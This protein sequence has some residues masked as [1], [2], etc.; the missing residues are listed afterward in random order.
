MRVFKLLYRKCHAWYGVI[1]MSFESITL[2]TQDKY[3]LRDTMKAS[4]CTIENWDFAVKL[5]YILC[6]NAPFIGEYV[7]SEDQFQD[8]VTDGRKLFS[9]L[10]AQGMQSLSGLE[11][12]ELTC[13][14]IFLTQRIEA[15]RNSSEDDGQIW[16]HILS[17]LGYDEIQPSLSWQSCYKKMTELIRTNVPYFAEY[18]QKYYNTLRI[19]ALTPADSISELFE[20]IYSFYRNN[21]ECQYNNADNAFEILTENI[22]KRLVNDDNSDDAQIS[23]GSGFWKLK[24]SLKFL[25]SHEPTYMAAVCDAIAGKMDILLR[26]DTPV[27]N[28][29]NRWD[30]LLQE[31]FDKKTDAEKRRMQNVRLRQVNTKI[32]SKSEQ[33]HPKYRLE[34]DNIFICIPSIRLP[35]I[36]QRPI[37]RLYQSGNLVTERTLSVYGN[38][39]CYTTREYSLSLIDIDYI[40]W[41]D[42]LNFQLQIYCDEN[43]IYDSAY[44][45][46]REYIIFNSFG[47]ESNIERCTNGQIRL[48]TDSYSIVEIDDPNEQ[49]N[50]SSTKDAFQLFEISLISA[51]KIVVNH[52][53]ILLS[54]PKKN[55][56]RCYF[57][58]M[59]INGMRLIQGENECLAFS[60]PPILHIVL[61]SKDAAQNYQLQFEKARTHSLYEFYDSKTNSIE[62]PL[63]SA[64]RFLHNIGIKQFQTGKIVAEFCY[65]VLPKCSFQF[66]SPFFLNRSGEVGSVKISMSGTTIQ[67]RFSLIENQTEIDVSLGNQGLC[68]KLAVP[69]INIT[70]DGENA[71]YWPEHIWHKAIPQTTFIQIESPESI[72]VRPM[73]GLSPLQHLKSKKIFDL[74]NQ[75]ATIDKSKESLPLGVLIQYD[76]IVVQQK[77]TEIHIKPIFL[78]SPITREGSVLTWDPNGKYIG[79]GSPEFQIQLENDESQEPWTYCETL[80]KDVM[81]R[82]FSCAPGRYECRVYL[83]GDKQTSPFQRKQDPQLLWDT[84]FEI[85]AKPEERFINERVYLTRAHF[86]SPETGH[87][88]TASIAT[89][90]AIIIDIQYDG[91][92]DYDGAID[93][94]EHFYTGILSFKTPDGRLHYMNRGISCDYETINPIRFCV[95]HDHLLVFNADGDKLQL[96]AKLFLQ[97]KRVRILNRKELFS[98]EKARQWLPIADSFEYREE[99]DI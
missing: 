28:K 68:C 12:K 94:T 70:V 16:K 96:N 69:K 32:A 50:D 13:A 77:L 51:R 20:I 49:Y 22:Q 82:N 48:L 60:T 36:T 3:A 81:E 55:N 47:L 24:S 89:N 80:K 88:E 21:L 65:M 33:I 27:L 38:E 92:D 10:M 5:C 86:W 44:E 53:D 34:N 62:I 18:G 83:N 90:D 41:A 97:N 61:D 43:K 25:L 98:Q 95:E 57:T 8:V 78:D 71:L 46:Y 9:R 2:Q 74:G 31:W 30:V 63:P 73:L 39:M 91:F 87:D 67:Q 54:Q 40:S 29:N 52:V 17:G 45:L 56:F 14:A 84:L 42:S 37:L 15:L 4:P 72:S 99:Y 93:H 76:G 79:D 23:F 11:Q 26:G 6:A 66:S 1:T 75:L 85:I 19:Q 35:E 64:A 58:P 7:P 59:P